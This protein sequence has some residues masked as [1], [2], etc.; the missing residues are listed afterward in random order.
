[1]LLF[2][3]WNTAILALLASREPTQLRR[4]CQHTCAGRYPADTRRNISVIITPKRRRFDVIMTLLIVL[5]DHWVY[6]RHL[7]SPYWLPVKQHIGNN[8]QTLL[9]MCKILRGMTTSHSADILAMYTPTKMKATLTHV[10]GSFN[11]SASRARCLNNPIFSNLGYVL[12]VERISCVI[13]FSQY[14]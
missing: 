1:M 13:F 10:G 14:M 4:M 12:H 5:F 3:V 2:I 7:S 11:L 6:I 8:V 9:C